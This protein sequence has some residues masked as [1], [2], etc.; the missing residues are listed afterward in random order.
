MSIEVTSPSATRAR[1]RRPTVVE[2]GVIIVAAAA[3]TLVRQAGLHSW[4]TVWAE[5]GVIF[6]SGTHSVGQIF[7]GYAGYLQ[8]VPRVVGF[9]A[10]AFALDDLARYYAVAGA[11]ITAVCAVAVWHFTRRLITS[12]VLRAVLA[13]SVVLLPALVF[14]QLANIANTI[15]AL[16][17]AG[18]WAI[19]YR[20]RS[21]PDAAPAAAVAFLAVTS[22]GLVLAFVPVMAL[23]VWQR[24]D[25]PTFVV[26]GAFLAG[27]LVQLAVMASGNGPEQLG[28]TH[29]GDVPQ[30]FAV[31][32]FGSAVVGEHWVGDAWSA[33]G[34]GFA[35]LATVA[36]VVLVA[37][38]AWFSTPRLRFLGLMTIAYA[39][40]L[41]VVSVYGR[42]TVA[43]RIA[44][45][46][47]TS[48]ATRYSSLSIWLLMSGMFIMVSGLRPGT[49]KRVVIVAFAVQFALIAVVGFRATNGRS[50]GPAWSTSLQNARTACLAPGAAHTDVLI[51]SVPPTPNWAV[52]LTCGG[53]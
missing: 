37:A 34:V 29:I 35:V 8:L 15:W 14:E 42:G 5:D 43:A 40:A 49:A 30:I 2:W 4:R 48:I 51:V 46:G 44:D 18:W 47:Y 33:L 27:V 9:G 31:R 3:L 17:F 20:P 1:L 52:K 32:V 53:P 45:T 41:W 24:R 25:K 23:M 16:S 28:P 50:A 36:V 11:L 38:L 21:L 13:V 39:V 12:H 6:Y 19:L 26:A 22:N 10:H 7:D